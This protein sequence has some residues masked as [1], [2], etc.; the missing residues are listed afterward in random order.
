MNT[1]LNWT[2][3]IFVILGVLMCGL[4]TRA[5]FSNLFRTRLLRYTPSCK[6]RSAPQGYCEI[7]G[8]GKSK[9]DF[10][11]TSPHDGQTCLWYQVH[12][13]RRVDTG[14]IDE[15]TGES[16][17]NTWETISKE[18]SQYPL[19]IEDATGGCFVFPYLA[20]VTTNYLE[21]TYPT[22]DPNIRIVQRVIPPDSTLFTVGMFNTHRTADEL[23]QHG[24]PDPLIEALTPYLPFNSLSALNIGKRP[25]LISDR[26]QASLQRSY[27]QRAFWSLIA[28][29]AS[30]CIVL[31]MVWVLYH[32]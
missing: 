31:W 24:L 21:Q 18:D 8:T 7:S 3:V 22:D 5:I 10:L 19:Y 12:R 26:Q 15:V 32:G 30:L 23:R 4:L 11:V 25:Y 16:T 27:T 1:G 20:E 29:S 9:P 17:S 13:Q 14:E 28:G 6:I 2:V